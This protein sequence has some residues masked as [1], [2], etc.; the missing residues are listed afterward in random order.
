MSCCY[1]YGCP[2]TVTCRG[3]PDA[4]EQATDCIC[5]E[6]GDRI[7]IGD[8]Y[9]TFDHGCLCDTCMQNMRA[10]ELAHILGYDEHVMTIDDAE[11]YARE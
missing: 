11:A 3:C 9:W 5:T 8:V 10:A 4:P 1:K 6:C 2:G 7:C